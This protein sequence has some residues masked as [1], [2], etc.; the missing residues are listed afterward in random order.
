MTLSPMLI[1]GLNR[2]CGVECE[3]D[4]FYFLVEEDEGNRGGEGRV[5]ARPADGAEG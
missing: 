3:A 1:L 5:D 4:N 2:Q